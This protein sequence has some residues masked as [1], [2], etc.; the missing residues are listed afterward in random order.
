M[1][2]QRLTGPD[3]GVLKYDL[4]TALSVAGLNGSPTVQTSFMRL[5]ALVTARYNWRADEFC[6]GQRD[7]A[8]MWSVNERTVKREIKRLVSAGVLICKRA[9]VRG[10]VGAYRLNYG[11]IARL[12]EP[13][14]ALVGPDFEARMQARYRPVET[15]VIKLETYLRDDPPAEVMPR[16]QPWD[17][18]RAE[19]A[20]GHPDLFQAWFAKLAFSSCERGDLRLK[21]PSSFVQRYVE[22]HHMPVLL[23]AAEAEFGPLERVIFEV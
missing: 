7:M 17:R 6:V 19:L 10:R 16:G 18:V 20:A 1:D 23:A 12:S 13:C 15:K 4:L 9:G 22:T 5:M 11:E 2:P 3:A 21:A 14:W 8:R